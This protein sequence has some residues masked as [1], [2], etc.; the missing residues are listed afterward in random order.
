MKSLSKK[1]KILI[2]SS[3]STVCLAVTF[4]FVGVTVA[5]YTYG[6]KAKQSGYGLGGVRETSIFFNANKWREGVDSSGNPVEA[7]YYIY[8]WYHDSGDSNQ[9]I[10]S[11]TAH[12]SLTV[13]TTVMDLYVF[14][15]D[16][17]ILN[18]MLFLRCDPNVEVTTSFSLGSGG[19]WNQTS[20]ITYSSSKNYYCIDSWGNDGITTASSN[21]ITRS[22]SPGSYTY[23]WA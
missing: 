2:V 9:V 16:T 21:K 7:A 1:K 15:Y 18:R 23:S 5:K 19:V 4:S 12:I 10:I 6:Q 22:G 8:A 13:S 11:P 14:E 20:D 17:S 3:L